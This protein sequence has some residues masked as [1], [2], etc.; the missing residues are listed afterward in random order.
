MIID[1]L[2][3]VVAVHE[4]ILAVAGGAVTIRFRI[5]W[6]DSG[7]WFIWGAGMAGSDGGGS[8]DDCEQS[9]IA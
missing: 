4:M 6:S 9:Y 1:D 3:A 5:L 7:L 8:S 2:E